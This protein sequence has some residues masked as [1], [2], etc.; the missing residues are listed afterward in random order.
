[1]KKEEGKERRKKRRG[2]MTRG[3]PGGQRAGAPEWIN[4]GLGGENHKRRVLSLG[5]GKSKRHED[6]KKKKDRRER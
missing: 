5:Q 1:M 2:E 3:T 4:V 6:I